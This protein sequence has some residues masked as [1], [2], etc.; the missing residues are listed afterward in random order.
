MYYAP[1]GTYFN[2]NTVRPRVRGSA[3]TSQAHDAHDAAHQA[4]GD[5]KALRSKHLTAPSGDHET[6]LREFSHLAA[7]APHS[8]AS[9]H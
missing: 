3:V 7:R 4:T 2:L 1:I 8:L 9:L 5:D 6:A